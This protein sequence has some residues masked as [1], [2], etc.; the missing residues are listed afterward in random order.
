MRQPFGQNFLVDRNIAQKIVE[1][2]GVSSSDTVLEIGPGKGILTDYL[3]ET[4]GKLVAVEIDRALAADLSVR[5]AEKENVSIVNTDFLHYA[6]PEEPFKVVANLPYSVSTAVIE[7]ILPGTGWQSA[8][9]MVQKEVGERIAAVRGTKA[10][11]SFSLLCQYYADVKKLFTVGPRC[12]F[13]RPKVDSVVL[14]MK[15]RR[16]PEPC[17]ELFP[18]IRL[19]FQQ[20]RKTVGNA[21]SSALDCPKQEVLSA[22]S[23]SG[24]DP[25]ARPETLALRD[26]QALTYSL[27]KYIL[28]KVCGR[29]KA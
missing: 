19:A 4:A 16:P 12:F 29:E 7:K 6:I 15:N 28:F 8:V 21:L 9:V 23:A 2:G 25:M 13:P 5:Y 17:A 3:S 22:L 18:L 24:I 14:C 27:K 26:Y 10:Y 11:G 20:R 1:A